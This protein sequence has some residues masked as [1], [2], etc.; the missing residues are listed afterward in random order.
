MSCLSCGDP[1][2]NAERLLVE[3]VVVSIYV[4]RQWSE[5]LTARFIKRDLPVIVENIERTARGSAEAFFATVK[6]T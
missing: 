6:V 2:P 1:D 3:E 5:A 4:P